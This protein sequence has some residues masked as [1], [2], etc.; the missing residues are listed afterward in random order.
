MEQFKALCGRIQKD[1]TTDWDENRGDMT[2][3][4]QVQKKAIIGYREEVDYFKERI[5][6]RVRFYGA[7]GTFYPAWYQS[8][9]DGIYHENWGLAGVA[10]WF[11]EPYADSSSAKIIGD[12][13]YFL[14]DGRMERMPQTID[15]GRREQLLRAFLL[16]T[17]EERMDKDSYEIYMLDGTRITVF[18]GAM[19]K[20]GQDT[21][22]FRR[23]VVPNYTFEEQ[24]D[25]GTIPREAIPLFKIM[26]E[27][28]FNVVFTGP[29]RSAKTTFLSTWQSYEAPHLE[30]VMVETDPEI[31]LHKLMPQAPLVQI[32]ADGERLS[33]VSKNLLRSD[34]DY[35]ILAEARDGIALETGIRMAGKGTR[36]MKMTFHLR[37]PLDFPMDAAWEIV[38]SRGGTLGE[39]ARKVAG[40]FDYI[41]HFVQRPDKRQK[42]LR[43]IYELSLQRETGT[44]SVEPLCLYDFAEDQW[45]FRYRFSSEKQAIAREECPGSEV[46]LE[47]QLRRLAQQFPMEERKKGGTPDGRAETLSAGGSSFAAAVSGG[48]GS[49]FGRPS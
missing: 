15:A 7:E 4:L 24:A 42:K 14:K 38:K 49:D 13:I 3:M 29:L 32:L 34:A 37:N 21:I 45:T 36:R 11:T 25:R 5:A 18:R 9:V 8:L 2:R 6:E 26:V 16:K 23:Y 48:G 20:E 27:A 28:G 31:P 19:V 39:T 30:G 1:L 33:V 17:P 41:F 10:E 46:R 22:I 40:S 44:I 47:E 43:G 35:I 12:R